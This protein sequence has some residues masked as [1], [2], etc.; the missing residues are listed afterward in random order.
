MIPSSEAMAVGVRKHCEDMAREI[1]RR[2][3][4]DPRNSDGTPYG[5]E[6]AAMLVLLDWFLGDMLP[7]GRGDSTP[8]RDQGARDAQNSD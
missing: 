3:A 8:D 1:S 4:E 5:V 7:G 2:V 6:R